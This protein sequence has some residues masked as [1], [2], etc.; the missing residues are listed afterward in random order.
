MRKRGFTLLELILAVAIIAVLISLVVVAMGR[1]RST[2][3]RTRTMSSLQGL[4]RG[5][6]AYSTD[7]N[8]AL[9]PGFMPGQTLQQLRIRAEA[10]G[11]IRLDQDTGVVDGSPWVWRLMPYI[12][13]NWQSLFEDYGNEAVVQTASLNLASGVYGPATA[14]PAAGEIG[15]ASVPAIGMNTFFFG[16]DFLSD[17]YD[18]A[19]KQASQVRNAS[20]AIVFAPTREVSEE[21]I[22]IDPSGIG[23][24]FDLV[25]GSVDLRPPAVFQDGDGNWSKIQWQ[26]EGEAAAALGSGEWSRGGGVPMARWGGTL[27]PVAKFD[28]GTEMLDLQ[29]D[30]G[31]AAGTN[32]PENRVK[33]MRN[34]SPFAV[35]RTSV[36][37]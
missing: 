13:D 19:A 20:R 23:P 33:I 9:I 35:G 6:T 4:I 31:W 18:Q 26:V 30:L 24:R 2:A 32:T 28:G 25:F 1:A 15:I 8:G 29:S 3:Q 5:Y 16:G 17:E 14:D 27:I 12:D 34:W 22:P 11:G 37:Q 10:P 36:Q 7:N 21:L